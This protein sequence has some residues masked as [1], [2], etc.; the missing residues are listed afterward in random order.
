MSWFSMIQFKM[1]V[2]MH[3]FDKLYNIIM[4]FYKIVF[5]AKIN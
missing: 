5:M 4:I 2:N 1:M 3:T